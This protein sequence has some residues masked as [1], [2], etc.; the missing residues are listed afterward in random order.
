M[1]DPAWIKEFPGAI[2]V[3]DRDGVVRAMNDKAVASFAADGGAALVGTNVL[4]CHPEP[5][6]TKLRAIMEKGRTNVYTIEKN[7]TKKLVFQ[8]PWT[9]DGEHRG[10]IEL[11]LEIP[12]ELPHYVRK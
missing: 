10:I 8:S 5:A 2:T 4:D 7:G 12:F 9:E 1:N 6:R 3:A 11:V